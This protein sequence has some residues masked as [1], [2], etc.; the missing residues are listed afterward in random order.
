MD[1]AGVSFAAFLIAAQAAL[2]APPKAADPAPADCGSVVVVRCASP[3]PAATPPPPARLRGARTPE[4]SLMDPVVVEAPRL[5]APPSLQELMQRAARNEG[6][7]SYRAR[8]IGTSNCT[9]FEPCVMNCCQCTTGG[10]SGPALFTG[11]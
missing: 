3:A 2:P 11:R 8:N 5:P 7:V 10:N 9:C 1:L 6:P 4:P